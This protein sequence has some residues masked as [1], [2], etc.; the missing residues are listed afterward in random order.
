M[1]I[2][3][4][5]LVINVI[6]SVGYHITLMKDLNLT[7]SVSEASAPFDC[8]CV[9]GCQSPSFAP[10][11]YLPMC[12]SLV[13]TTSPPS[14]Q[15]RVCLC[16]RVHLSAASRI[17]Q[18]QMTA[19]PDIPEPWRGP[20]EEG[21]VFHLHYFNVCISKLVTVYIHLILV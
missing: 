12:S 4:I 1:D 3:M 8:H 21:V 6:I 18:C 2:K 16:S 10:I 9:Y 13:C 15:S 19:T 20:A 14:H 17:S 7:L 5:W 11:N